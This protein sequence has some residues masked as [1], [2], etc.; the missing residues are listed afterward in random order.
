[1]IRIVKGNVLWFDGRRTHI[2]PAGSV[3]AA[4]PSLEARWVSEG[5]AEY[6]VDAPESSPEPEPAPAPLPEPDP[7]AE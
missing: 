1:M 6:A 5:V 2:K 4:D 3:F 7:E